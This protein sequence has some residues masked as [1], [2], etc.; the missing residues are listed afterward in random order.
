MFVGLGF[1]DCYLDS[2]GGFFP[3]RGL[4]QCAMFGW[5]YRLGKGV[6]G[7]F[8]NGFK[9]CLSTVQKVSYLPILG[10]N[11]IYGHLHTRSIYTQSE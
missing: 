10:T 11:G 7:V 9:V 1:V 6:R 4:V 3:F 5:M 8:Q 2:W